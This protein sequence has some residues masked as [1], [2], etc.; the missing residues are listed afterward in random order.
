MS[1]TYEY[2][3]FVSYTHEPP[4]G[5]WVREFFVAELKQW[6]SAGELTFEPRIFWDK[7]SLGAGDLLLPNLRR[8][9]LYSKCIVPV[10]SNDYFRSSWC[11]AEWESFR[12]RGEA[13]GLQTS[14][15][16][17]PVRF[18]GKNFPPKANEVL[19]ENFYEFSS[20]VGKD[21]QK[22]E[23]FRQRVQAF[24]ERVAKVVLSAPPHRVD[25]PVIDAM[26]IETM[27]SR[28]EALNTLRE[29]YN[30]TKPA[31]VKPTLSTPKTAA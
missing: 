20:L 6:L 22:F 2:D 5:P 9:I 12:R 17:I 11:V 19:S 21:S 10:W 13:V 26:E 30:L 29:I 1:D 8:C 27:S 31:S 7:T 18:V 23:L 24:S 3:V 14:G 28:T 4:V 25:W 15:L 16:V